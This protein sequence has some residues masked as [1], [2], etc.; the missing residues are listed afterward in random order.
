MELGMKLY[1]SA[2]VTDLVTGLQLFVPGQLC[3]VFF[4]FGVLAN[5][6]L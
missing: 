4:R 1:E 2:C 3:F 6:S 5:D